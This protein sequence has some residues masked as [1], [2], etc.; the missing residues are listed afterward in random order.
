MNEP[1]ERGVARAILAAREAKHS[2]AWREW[3]ECFEAYK[4]LD[5]QVE[6]EGSSAD[7]ELV[8][9]LREWRDFYAECVREWRAEGIG[10][11]NYAT[12]GATPPLSQWKQEGAINE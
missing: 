8:K 6:K 1:I 11:E 2:P 3:M 12:P 10:V 7:P 4:E 9:L 5:R